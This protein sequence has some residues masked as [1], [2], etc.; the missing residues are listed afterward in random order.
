MTKLRRWTGQ[1]KQA[2]ERAKDRRQ[3]PSGDRRLPPTVSPSTA[4]SE[5]SVPP[6]D[7]PTA[8]E[9]VISRLKP[10]GPAKLDIRGT[11]VRKPSGCRPQP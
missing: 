5:A 11:Q 2:F 8:V 3:E 6:P 7:D 10:T 1:A 9:R 4:V